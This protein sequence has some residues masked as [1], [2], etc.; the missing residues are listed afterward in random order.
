MRKRC[1]EKPILTNPRPIVDRQAPQTRGNLRFRA[2]EVRAHRIL[3]WAEPAVRLVRP[4]QAIGFT[5]SPN[6]PPNLGK[7]EVGTPQVLSAS[8]AIFSYFEGAW[9]PG[10][11]P[12]VNLKPH[13]PRFE[14]P[15]EW[16]WLL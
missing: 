1:L 3:Q 8:T 5:R 10:V 11:R 15:C 12:T 6:N 16:D 13:P 2:F 7:F 14:T 4:L 9:Q